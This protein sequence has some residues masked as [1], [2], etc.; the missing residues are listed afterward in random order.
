[1][2]EKIFKLFL[3]ISVFFMIVSIFPNKVFSSWVDD[4]KSFLGAADK[5]VNLN[6]DKLES[7]SNDIYNLLS[8]I[9]MII[10]VVVGIILGITYML[11]AAEEKAKVKES[12]IPYV[13]GCI[14]IFGAFGIWKLLI[15][16]FKVL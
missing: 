15:N 14:V 11:V 12:L 2:Q 5:T 4:A 1:M 3:I 9:G 13:I 10:A 6:G 7:A 8:S 16:I